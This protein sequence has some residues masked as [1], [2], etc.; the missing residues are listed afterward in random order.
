MKIN[1]NIRN[2]ILI[3][4]IAVTTTG[5]NP[6][7]VVV[8]PGHV[9]VVETLGNIKNNELKSGFYAGMNPLSTIHNMSS[10]TQQVEE[11]M[12]LTTGGGEGLGVTLDVSVLYHITP[13][14]SPS[15]YSKTGTNYE[16]IIIIPNLRSTTRNVVSG[17]TSEDLYNSQLREKISTEID[18]TL[19]PIY[20]E[21]DIGLE[22]VLLRGV[23]LSD[24]IVTAIEN[25][26]KARQESEQMQY[27]LSK[28]RQEKDRKSIEAEGIASA[29]SIIAKSLTPEYLQW[30]Y[31][32]T[33]ESLAKSQNTT[34]LITPYDQK[35]TPMLPLES[36]TK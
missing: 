1:K 3:G 20:A 14:K 21:K 27:I 11:K 36:K 8:P 13:G 17:H 9:G 7:C 10:R 22:K 34:F 24:T 12:D 33:L 16:E 28:E 25:K 6:G 5:C 4:L 19:R 23:H 30:R 18:S 26:V 2:K 29:Q 15:I 35:I 32:T 31:I